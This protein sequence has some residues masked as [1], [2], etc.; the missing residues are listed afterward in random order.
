MNTPELICIIITTVCAMITAII[1][2]VAIYKTNRVS[3]RFDC[4]PVDKK[5]CESRHLE[6][7]KETERLHG[8]VSSTERGIEDR[9]TARFDKFETMSLES[10][11]VMHREIETIGKEVA[12]LKSASEINAATIVRIEGKFDRVLERNS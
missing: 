9:V 8:R 2:W 6:M 4:D 7:K 10:R 1:A 11:R 12:A 3:V 5:E